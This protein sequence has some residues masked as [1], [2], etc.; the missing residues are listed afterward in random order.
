MPLPLPN[1]DTP[2]YREL[3]GDA[4][5]L[6]P[7]YAPAWTDHNESD[8]GIT[9]VEL[10]AWLVEQDVYRV[11]RIPE[12]HRRKFLELTGIVPKPPR[13]ARAVLSLPAPTDVRIP[14]GTRFDADAVP[15]TS[16][17]RMRIAQTALVGVQSWDGQAFEELTDRWRGGLPLPPWGDDPVLGGGDPPALLLGFDKPFPDHSVSLW[18]SVD[19]GDD[20]GEARRLAEE[21]RANEAACAPLRPR[22]TCNGS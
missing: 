22:A 6:I 4:H 15:F 5:A 10:L 8:P 17:N 12:R 11:N 21:E 18:I 2:R 19:R 20:R 13:A 3:V 7:R 14:A 16:S 1:L 9:L